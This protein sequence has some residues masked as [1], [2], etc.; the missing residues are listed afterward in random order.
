M[1]GAEGA[2]TAVRGKLD[3]LAYVVVFE[4]GVKIKLVVCPTIH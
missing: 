3:P 4:V 1:I 2:A